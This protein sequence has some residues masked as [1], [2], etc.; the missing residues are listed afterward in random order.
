LSNPVSTD[1]QTYWK[2]TLSTGN[3]G[4]AL[5]MFNETSELTYRKKPTRLAQHWQRGRLFAVQL[6]SQSVGLGTGVVSCSQTAL[7]STHQVREEH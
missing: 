4:P 1:R 6:R 3:P 5:F 7:P 2:A